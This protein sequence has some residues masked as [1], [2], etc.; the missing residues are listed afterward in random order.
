MGFNVTFCDDPATVLNIAGDFLASQPVRHNIILSLLQ[1]RAAFREP[2]RYW[3]A[4][5][6]GQIVG[7]VFQSPPT[8]AAVLTPMESGVTAAV[9][10]AIPCAGVVLL[11]VNGEAATAAS[12]AGHWTERFKSAAV[13]FQGMRLYDVTEVREI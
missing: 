8:I 12:V 3:M 6:G 10:D 2:G 11:G 4:S 9:A 7:V 13:P 5:R 1:T